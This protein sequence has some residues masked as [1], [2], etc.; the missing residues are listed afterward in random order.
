[1]PSRC[2]NGERKS[3]KIANKGMC[4][5]KKENINP[6]IRCPNGSRK[7]NRRTLECVDKAT[8]ILRSRCANG[9]R[10]DRD[11]NCVKLKRALVRT[12]PVAASPV[13]DDNK[14]NA[15]AEAEKSNGQ[16][17]AAF[18]DVSLINQYESPQKTKKKLSSQKKSS[19][20]KNAY[21]PE[22]TSPSKN[23]MYEEIKLIEGHESPVKTL[24]PV[25]TNKKKK[26]NK[27]KKKQ[28]KKKSSSEK[29][30][31]RER[32]SS[33]ST[34]KPDLLEGIDFNED[35]NNDFNNNEYEN[36][37]I[38]NNDNEQDNNFGDLDDLLYKRR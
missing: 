32:S 30:L 29:S 8:I 36:N 13:I 22:K 7:K 11:G 3:R 27:Q 26:K 31:L 37:N 12:P 1:M 15:Q 10:K 19:P 34:E 38:K 14:E 25:K 23:K 17:E 2:K 18:K 28:T 33:S 4:E 5:P 20:V 6:R 16:V 35:Q 24:S 9:L 21:S